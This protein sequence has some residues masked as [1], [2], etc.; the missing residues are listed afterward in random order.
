M[1]ESMDT[2]RDLADQPKAEVSE[3]MG[4]KQELMEAAKEA[5]EAKQDVI[6]SSRQ[7]RKQIFKDLWS[8]ALYAWSYGRV[9]YWND[10]ENNKFLPPETRIKFTK[11]RKERES[12]DMGTPEN[13][14]VMW[15]K[16][17]RWSR[18]EDVVP[19]VSYAKSEAY[20]KSE[21][22]DTTPWDPDTTPWDVEQPSDSTPPPS[23]S[24]NDEIEMMW[25]SR[26]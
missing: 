13:P 16:M 11:I 12:R 8:A 17:M 1:P 24:T 23:I 4:E 21:V 18:G 10:P 2:G 9:Y 22:P 25:G 6:N 7:K 5:E 20:A 19:N 15:D 14:D 26:E 3:P